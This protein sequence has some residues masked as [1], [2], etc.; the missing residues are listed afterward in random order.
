MPNEILTTVYSQHTIFLQRI[1]ATQGNAVIPYLT[2]I[3][4]DVQRIFN[5][6]R[7]R[8]KTAANQAA[9]QKAINE[10]S[11]GHL[12]DYITQLKVSN[13]EIGTNEAEF[14]AA[15]LDKIVIRDDF[16][17]VIPSAAQVNAIAIA[18]PIK[19]SGTEF[20]TYSTMMRNY[21]TKWSDEIDAAVQ[22]GFVS[23]QSINEIADNVFNEMRLQ[24]STTSKNLLNRAHRSAKA[25]ATTGV[26]HYSNQARIAFGEENRNI[27]KGYRG[28]SVLDSRTSRVCKR[29][30][31]VVRTPKDKDWSSF[32]PPRHRWCRSAIVYEVDER[33]KLNDKDTKRASSFNVDGKRDPKPVSSEGIYYQKMKELKESDQ[34]FALKSPTLGEA[35]RKLDNPTEFAESTVNSLGQPLTI[36]EMRE[37]DNALGDILKDMEQKK[38]AKRKT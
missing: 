23:G 5:R 1:G 26:N 12:Q 20:T 38:N 30:D 17:S 34:D 13:R 3:E 2:L 18:T 22:N 37:A 32:V 25:V 15:T 7:D 19:L 33:F 10:A 14:A 16:E 6:Y 28:I 11:R 8:P 29:Y 31:Q 27:I 9:I 36:K 35:F 21:W 24:K 4:E